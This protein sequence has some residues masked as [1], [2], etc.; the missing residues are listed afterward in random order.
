MYEAD[1][2]RADGFPQYNSCWTCGCSRHGCDSGKCIT[3]TVPGLGN[4]YILKIT[5][6]SCNYRSDC[7]KLNSAKS[8]EV[9]FEFVGRGFLKEGNPFLKTPVL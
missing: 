2:N 5:G 8:K 6:S 4:D 9:D 3:G 7:V 1:Y